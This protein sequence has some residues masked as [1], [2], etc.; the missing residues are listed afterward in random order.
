MEE[1]L[2]KVQALNYALTHP[3]IMCPEAW[4]PG[5]ESI[6]LSQENA[7]KKQFTHE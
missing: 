1:L 7:T 2:R 3:Q 6:A 4:K 5:K